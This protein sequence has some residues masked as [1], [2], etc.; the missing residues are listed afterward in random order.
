[1]DLQQFEK[2]IR[3]DASSSVR[4]QEIVSSSTFSTL[5]R[6][7]YTWMALALAITGFTA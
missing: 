1:M 6:K 4:Q 3:E 7:V 2:S 5:M